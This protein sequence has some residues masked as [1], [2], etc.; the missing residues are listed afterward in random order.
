ME[1]GKPI[2]IDPPVELYVP[3]KPAGKSQCVLY[4]SSHTTPEGATPVTVT[5]CM[6][7]DYI[8]TMQPC[9]TSDFTDLA[10]VH[11]IMPT[12]QGEALGNE[13]TTA[14]G[15]EDLNPN[16][17]L[18]EWIEEEMTSGTDVT[19]RE[20]G[21]RT[22]LLRE[23]VKKQRE[24]H[25][26]KGSGVVQV[27]LDS[28]CLGGDYIR[29]DVARYLIRNNVDFFEPCNS[30]VCGAFGTCVNSIFKLRVIFQMFNVNK[31]KKFTTS[32]KVLN[33]LPYD[34]I[35]G[36]ETMA[37]NCL[38][39]VPSSPSNVAA[40][41]DK[42]TEVAN[43]QISV[44]DTEGS[45]RRETVNHTL[46]FGREA[47]VLPKRASPGI[48]RV[49]RHVNTPTTARAVP[50]S[51]SRQSDGTNPPHGLAPESNN[52][53]IRMEADRS[54]SLR[55]NLD[56]NMEDA[57]LIP[58]RPVTREEH[59]LLDVNEPGLLVFSPDESGN[60]IIG[61]KSQE[62]MRPASNVGETDKDGDS[63]PPRTLPID[64]TLLVPSSRELVE[65]NVNP[66]GALQQR[67]GQSLTAVGTPRLSAEC[68]PRK[69]RVTATDQG[70]LRKGK[71]KRQRTRRVGTTRHRPG[72][73]VDND[74]PTPPPL[75]VR[76]SEF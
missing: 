1:E 41:H 76:A 23:R 75:E 66:V 68:F 48:I 2:R 40:L 30:C 11:S 63:L 25:P 47:R 73:P 16:V 74:Q 71:N 19:V 32:L 18:L 9:L 20:V 45:L 26:R 28:G 39:I 42:S 52:S 62:E 17:D 21:T 50:M 59:E 37:V 14:E 58:C 49:P 10:I 67:E 43:P 15:L 55:E 72:K 36:R 70:C 8:H 5:T 33:Q 38:S 53:I 60:S 56:V 22:N 31:Y 6:N 44:T 4:G 34:I 64:E 65:C 54:E 51:K 7:I 69:S 61:T 27:F 12:F 24:D 35:L 29:E 46:V 13:E 57:G 3:G